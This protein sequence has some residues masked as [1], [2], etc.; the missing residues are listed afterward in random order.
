MTAGFA[1][2]TSELLCCP[3]A[4][5]GACCYFI[6][7]SGQATKKPDFFAVVRLVVACFFSALTHI[8][9]TT[10]SSRLTRIMLVVVNMR[11]RTMHSFIQSERLLCKLFILRAQDGAAEYRK[12][13]SRQARR[14]LPASGFPG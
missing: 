7:P 3:T 2:F 4:R 1:G 6:K 10:A 14:R 5:L 8:Y 12:I 9:Q 13:P 11:F